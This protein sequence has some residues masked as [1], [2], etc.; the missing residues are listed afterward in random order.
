MVAEK[1]PGPLPKTVRLAV[2]RKGNTT[3]Y[4]AAI[5]WSELMVT[6]PQIGTVIGFSL[7]INDSDASDRGW[8]E[9]MGGIGLPK[10]ASLFGDLLLSD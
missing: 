8:I 5:P 9:Y 10:E 7:L 6:K 4:E 1:T 3:C 2:I